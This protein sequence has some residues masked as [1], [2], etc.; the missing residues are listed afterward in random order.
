[1]S[2]KF[3]F[4]SRQWIQVNGDDM[5]EIFAAARAAKYQFAICNDWIYFLS[6]KAHYRTELTINDLH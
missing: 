5:E 6:A 1:M 2:W 4:N 3:V